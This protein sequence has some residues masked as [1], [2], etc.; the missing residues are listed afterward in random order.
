MSLHE[1]E[2]FYFRSV[3][4]Y[5][6]AAAS[7]ARAIELNSQIG[8]AD[9]AALAD[10]VTKD[11]TQLTRNAWLLDNLG[12]VLLQARKPAAA[13][14]QLEA[15]QAAYSLAAKTGDW[16]RARNLR[17]LAEGYFRLG[18]ISQAIASLDQS[19]QLAFK[20]NQQSLLAMTEN[21]QLDFLDF[22]H[23]PSLDLALTIA[24]S[25]R[26]TADRFVEP[27]DWAL[28][29]KS[30]A[31]RVLARRVA[32][33]RQ[34]G[35][36]ASSKLA[37]ELTLVRAE[38]ARSAMQRLKGG[39]LTE[40]PRIEPLSLKEQELS[41]RVGISESKNEPQALWI[42]SPE[43][44]SS[45]PKDT[46][47]VEI[48]RFTVPASLA[49]AGC[50]RGPRYVAWIIPP[51]GQGEIGLVDLG[52]A[53]KIETAVAGFREVLTAAPDQINREGEQA[54]AEAAVASLQSLRTLIYEPLAGR[55]AA[56]R[57]WLISPDGALWLIPWAAIPLDDSTFAVERH[58]ITYLVSGRD[59]VDHSL[60]K[61]NGIPVVI[62]D[63]DYDLSPSEALVEL[64]QVLPKDQIATRG[65]ATLAEDLANARWPRLPGTATEAQALEP[66]CGP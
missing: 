5:D 12:A 15:A 22:W 50:P 59:L 48:S 27:A 23:R 31:Q 9:K 17:S 65:G 24:L 8:K 42:R 26:G 19:Q 41:R 36:V 34:E 39:S 56:T 38:L 54:A 28:N 61:A 11:Y 45:L 64:Q 66:R 2:A 47:L 60:L 21:E 40:E 33:S 32:L 55:L 6:E 35:D 53:D 7:L 37:E 63:P 3:G 46:V 14:E 49:T 13:V 20:A 16:D 4:N 51:T 1:A 62:A 44:R 10:I 52:P 29:G 25:A 43:V 57:N 18:R 58:E 30:L